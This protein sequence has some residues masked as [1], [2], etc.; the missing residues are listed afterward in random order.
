MRIGLNNLQLMAMQAVSIII[1]VA[2]CQYNRAQMGVG[3][4]L[5][6]SPSV[7]LSV[8]RSVYPVGG[9]MA[10]WIWMPFGLVSVVGRGIGVLD[11]G[12]D[13]QRGNGSFGDKCGASH[14]NQWGLVA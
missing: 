8:G 9:K 11:G 6:P 2:V 1:R 3:T 14:C 5:L 7:G 4:E 13:C 12:G 10:D